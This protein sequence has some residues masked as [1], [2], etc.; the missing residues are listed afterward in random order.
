MPWIDNLYYGVNLFLCS[1]IS[2]YGGQ[3]KNNIVLG[4]HGFEGENCSIPKELLRAEY[5]GKQFNP[6]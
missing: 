3:E 4:L 1:S 2:N 5:K 6:F